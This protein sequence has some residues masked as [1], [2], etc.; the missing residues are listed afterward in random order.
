MTKL[1]L[2]QTKMDYEIY[3]SGQCRLMESDL[4]DLR[5]ERQV[6]ESGA[7][8]LCRV[9]E[10]DV[11]VDARVWHLVAGGAFMLFP[12][13]VCIVR[14]ASEDFRVELL[15]YDRAMLR[16]AS[17][18]LEQTVYDDLRSDRLGGEERT[19]SEIVEGMFGLLRIYFSQEGCQCTDQL[20]LLQLKAFF[21]GYYDWLRRNGLRPALGSASLRVNELF[22]EFMRLIERDCRV[23][24]RVGHYAECL[25]VS[26]K[27]LTRIV[28]EVNGL[29]PKAMI[30]HY[31]TMQ[32]K[33]RLRTSDVSVKELAWE[34]GFADASF[35]GRWFRVRT[36]MTP[37]EFRR[38]RS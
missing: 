24:Q 18:Q 22:N 2:I 15:L 17:L 8:L 11:E 4:A 6:L 9:G 28:R 21:L 13:D 7:V 10:A 32:V 19:V 35:F 25:R 29:T 14:R 27:Y 23:S 31:V 38:T 12:G 26:A 34:F 30:D 1:G 33:L 20:A 16:E 36:G 5:L 3:R 37:G